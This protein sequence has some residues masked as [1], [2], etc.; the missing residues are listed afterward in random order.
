M[1][2]TCQRESFYVSGPAAA[3]ADADKGFRAPLLP[4]CMAF[5]FWPPPPSLLQQISFAG[6]SHPNAGLCVICSTALMELQLPAAKTAATA[7]FL[8]ATVTTSFMLEMCTHI[9][10]CF[11]F[12]DETS[13]EG[14]GLP[15]CIIERGKM[16]QLI[17]ETGPENHTTHG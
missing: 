8:H 2:A 3:A 4:P 5:A 10:K 17:R 16:V 11:F 6:L 15:Q 12:F 1:K 13:S 14:G 9:H 7:V